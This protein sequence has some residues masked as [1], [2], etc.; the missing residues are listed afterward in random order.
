MHYPILTSL[1]TH[2]MSLI[3]ASASVVL[4]EDAT[5]VDPAA[6][7]EMRLVLMPLIS[8][9]LVTGA[10]ILLNPKP[11]TRRI[12]IGRALIALGSAVVC[13][14]MLQY[15]HPSLAAFA[16]KPFP[17]LFLGAVI[18]ALSYVLSRPFCGGL[19]RRAGAVAEY[20]LDALEAKARGLIPPPMPTEVKAELKK[21]GSGI[22]EKL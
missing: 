10:L 22:I 4:L 1:V 7:V 16:Q 9:V 6:F 13:P 21:A 15:I 11:E 17:L 18:T 5:T 3:V 12:V 8:G 2:S 14:Q 20:Q 19:Y